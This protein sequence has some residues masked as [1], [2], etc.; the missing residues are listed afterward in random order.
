MRRVPAAHPFVLEIG[1]EPLDELMVFTR[2]ADEAGVELDG[3]CRGD[4]RPHLH[5]E[6]FRHA[7]AAQEYFGDVA[8]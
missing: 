3:L 5:D 1:V 4:E 6:G 7:A 2:I 8:L